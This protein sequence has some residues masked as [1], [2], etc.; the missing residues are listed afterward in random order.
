MSRFNDFAPERALMLKHFG[1]R[2]AL[3]DGFSRWPIDMAREAAA[4]SIELKRRMAAGEPCALP[5]SFGTDKGNVPFMP[6]QSRPATTAT[7]PTAARKKP[8]MTDTNFNAR[9]DAVERKLAASIR[10]KGGTVPKYK[11]SRAEARDS[12][13][14]RAA[15]AEAEEQRLLDQHMPINAASARAHFDKSSMTASFGFGVASTRS[16]SGRAPV[17]A[18]APSRVAAGGPPPLSAADQAELDRAMPLP[19]PHATVRREGPGD[20]PTSMTFALGYASRWPRHW[21]PKPAPAPKTE[22]EKEEIAHEA[23]SRH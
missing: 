7:P 15:A 5:R 1:E 23:D 11:P 21:I 9:L 17:A 20:A 6:P 13:T 10:A 3:S 18:P 22:V 14:V 12:A 4:R 19:S 16:S 8:P 2:D